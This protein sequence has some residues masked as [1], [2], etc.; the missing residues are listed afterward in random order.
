MDL[1]H[2]TGFTGSEQRKHDIRRAVEKPAH[3]VGLGF[4]VPLGLVGGTEIFIGRVRIL[5]G[6]GNAKVG[7]FDQLLAFV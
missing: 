7:T 6:K 3:L 5:A 2:Q 1:T 4:L